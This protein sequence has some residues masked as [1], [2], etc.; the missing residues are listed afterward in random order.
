MSFRFKT[1]NLRHLNHLHPVLI[2]NEQITLQKNVRAVPMPL[3]DQ[4]GS[5]R[6]FQQTIKLM[7]K[8][9]EI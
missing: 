4:K 8:T 7:G 5:N 3:I 6:I 9:E 1:Q 2:A